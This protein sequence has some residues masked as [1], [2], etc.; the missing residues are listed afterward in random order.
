MGKGAS[1]GGGRVKRDPRD[2]VIDRGNPNRRFSETFATGCCVISTLRVRP[3]ALYD[4]ISQGTKVVL[5]HTLTRTHTHTHTHTHTVPHT[6]IWS[7]YRS[8]ILLT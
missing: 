5:V 4:F 2:N 7:L 1:W 6:R 8:H 3:T